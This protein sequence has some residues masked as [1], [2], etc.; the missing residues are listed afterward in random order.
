M[1][2]PTGT[3]R[4][5]NSQQSLL[6]PR[7]WERTRL[8]LFDLRTSLAISTLLLEVVALA[9]WPTLYLVD[10]SLEP[11]PF[12]EMI[13]RRF[14]AVST[15]LEGLKNLT[16]WLFPGALWSWEAL[17]T[18]FFH[19]LLIGF[20]AYAFAAW[21]LLR[22]ERRARSG[23][24]EIGKA[25]IFLP[26]LGLQLTFA[27]TPATLTTD[28][29][30]YAIYGEM[31][32]VYGANPFVHTPSEFPQ[33][34]LHYLIPIYWHDA[35]SA[36]GPSWVVV[37]N[38]VA[39]LLHS[40]PLIDE[41][42]VYRF[43]ANAAHLANVALIWAIAHR[44]RPGSEPAAAVSYGWNP[45]VLLEF[46]MNGHNDVLML[47]PLLGA[48]LLT[49]SGHT[50]L[51]AFA[52][53]TSVAQ[54]YTSVVAL[55]LFLAWGAWSRGPRA[56]TRFLSEVVVSRRLLGLVLVDGCIAL[57]TVVAFYAPFLG[58]G[59]DTFR[60]V[61]YWITGPRIQNYWPEPL[62]VAITAWITGPLQLGWEVVWEPVLSVFKNLAR[63]ALVG[64]IGWEMW[65]A[66][67]VEDA[68]AG[69]ARLWLVFLLL[70]NT[71]IMPWYYLWPLAIIAPL[72]WDSPLVRATA[73]LTLTA[74]IVMYGKQ[75]NFAPAGEWAGLTLVL[76]L[77]LWGLGSLVTAADMRRSGR[78]LAPAVIRPAE[79][80]TELVRS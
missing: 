65:R 49:M 69:A 73:G 33:S 31:P 44:L 46:A 4:L 47:T 43:I 17:V 77:L 25:W 15:V 63:L 37:S 9:L 26:L 74:T 72:G 27:F 35:P 7:L 64:A 8:F 2:A 78:G 39:S 24:T 45:A 34:A 56:Q 32:V 58:G 57:G 21:R 55:P 54:K 50:R 20:V 29:Y 13:R 51:A 6:T 16:D 40:H 28:I 10:S 52:L 38:V 19:A 71:W 42:I 12:G 70:V 18:F 11:S 79:E 48:V 30:N 53:G 62:L 66:R 59:W 5:E 23:Q 61:A 41:L 14:D 60:P 36:Y 76:P 68:L 67:R 1:A 75:L 22:S 3:D 80:A